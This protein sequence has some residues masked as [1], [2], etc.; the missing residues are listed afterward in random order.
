MLC[1]SLLFGLCTSMLVNSFK[2]ML[3]RN[4]GKYSAGTAQYQGRLKY[5]RHVIFIIAK[6]V[7]G[8]F[9]TTGQTRNTCRILVGKSKLANPKEK[10]KR[11]YN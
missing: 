11:G 4:V 2:N 7:K 3:F 5:S 6:S 1:D 8:N 10:K 9:N